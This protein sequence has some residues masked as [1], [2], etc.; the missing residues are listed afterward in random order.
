MRGLF[1]SCLV[2]TFLVLL[3]VGCEKVTE[4]TLTDEGEITSLIAELVWFSATGYYGLEDTSSA[5][6][7]PITPIFWWRELDETPPF[8]VD[9]QIVDSLR[10]VTLFSL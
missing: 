5:L 4:V 2:G 10:K 8:G 9:I 1:L 3:I 6:G 7:N